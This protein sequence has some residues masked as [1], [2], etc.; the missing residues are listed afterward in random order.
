MTGAAR[1]RRV[2]VLNHFA[3]PRSSPGGTRHVELF[4]RLEG[5]DHVILASNRNL[6][7]REVGVKDDSIHAVWTTPVAASGPSRILHWASYAVTACAAGLRQPTD[8]VYASSPHLLAGLAGW[9]LAK[10]KR[11][12]LIIE[13]RDLWPL[14]LVDMGQ[15]GA[16]SWLYRALKVLE[17]F[18]YRQA[19]AVVIL[20]EGNRAAVVADGAQADQVV[21]LPNGADPA[22]FEVAEDRETLRTRYGMEGVVFLYA[23]AHGKANGL[24]LVLDAAEEVRATHPEIR[25]WLVGD[26]YQKPDLVRS[27]EARGLINVIFHEPV[28]KSEMPALLAAADVGLHVLAD[29]PLFR[30]GVS[31]N[32]LFDYMAAGLPVLTNTLGEVGDL[33]RRARA[34]VAVESCRIASGAASLAEID[35]GLRALQGRNGR[36][37][38]V[39]N[40]SRTVLA[41][42]LAAVLDEITAKTPHGET[43]DED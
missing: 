31:P 12:P 21:F 33:V 10:V 24:E 18:L 17:R 3:V 39:Q 40:R 28:P 38:M 7:T 15:L 27:A 9:T 26:G 23:G 34:G 43:S 6:L 13:V 2:L 32:K 14:V 1:R 42:G 30:H 16:S 11:V 36:A 5:W 4:G 25:F 19:D 37:F 29:V 20:A 35:G 22:D 8:L 41:G